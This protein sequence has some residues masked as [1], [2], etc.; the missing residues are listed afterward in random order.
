[1]PAMPMPGA[2]RVVAR[3]VEQVVLAVVAGD[4]PLDERVDTDHGVD[5]RQQDQGAQRDV[6]R[7]GEPEDA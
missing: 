1:M 2:R 4:P 6:E 7:Q 5:E 3:P